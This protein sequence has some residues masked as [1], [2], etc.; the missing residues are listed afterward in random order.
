MVVSVMNAA[1]MLPK[2]KGSATML[3]EAERSTTPLKAYCAPMM[4]NVRLTRPGPPTVLRKYGHADD[5]LDVAKAA[6]VRAT[7][8]GGGGKENILKM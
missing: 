3:I 4:C 8:E 7:R 2:W 6:A 5:H 1:R